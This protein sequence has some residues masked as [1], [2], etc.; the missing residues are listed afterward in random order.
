MWNIN[1]PFI[2]RR[3]LKFQRG[4]EVQMH[5]FAK[6][7][8]ATTDER[9]TCNDGCSCSHHDTRDKQPIGHHSI[10]RI[11]TRV[12]AINM[13]NDISTLPHIV[14]DEHGF[15]KQPTYC[16]ITTTTM[17]QIRIKRFSTRRTKEHCAE[18]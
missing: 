6:D 12:Y 10:K 5:R 17:S 14:Q 16:D 8:K 13:K 11:D 2:Y 4:P 3:I 9:L 18:N 15:N 7:G 1:L